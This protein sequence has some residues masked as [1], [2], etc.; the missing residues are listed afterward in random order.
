M[1]CI[2]SAPTVPPVIRQSVDKYLPD[3]ACNGKGAFAKKRGVLQLMSF[4][5]LFA[6][7]H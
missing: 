1:A 3:M 2:L 7:L 4:V 5:S 6:K